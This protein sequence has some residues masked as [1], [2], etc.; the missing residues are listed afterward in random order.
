MDIAVITGASSG[1]G[2]VFAKQI[3]CMKGLDEIWLIARRRERLE[4]LAARLPVPVR[5]FAADLTKDEAFEEYRAALK[6][7]GTRVK[8][9]VNCAGFAKFGR[10]EEISEQDSL[11]M[12]TLNCR[13]L[14]KMTLQTLPFIPKG[15]RILQICSTS[16]FQ[17]LPGLNIYAATKAFVLHYSRALHRELKPKGITVTALCPG[18]MKTEFLQVAAR[19][20]N[21]KAVHNF[22]FVTQPQD[23]ARKALADC[24]KGKELSLYGV[25][26]RVHRAVAKLLPH[27]V[28]MKIWEQSQR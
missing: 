11:D 24:A 27:R 23:V 4:Q 19:H 20:A 15:G 9:L 10:C 16:S 14:V 28:V 1:L 22:Y 8:L 6:E 3:A 21:K 18:W 25:G 5:I 2:Y 26:N 17:P 12:I 7:A 13:A